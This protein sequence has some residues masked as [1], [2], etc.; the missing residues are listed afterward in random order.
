MI[1]GVR[2]VWF[3]QFTAARPRGAGNV[4]IARAGVAGNLYFILGGVSGFPV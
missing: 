4:G 3:P 1:A 2:Y